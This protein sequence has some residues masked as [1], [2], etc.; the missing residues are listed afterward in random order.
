MNNVTNSY[1]RSTYIHMTIKARLPLITSSCLLV[2]LLSV[3]LDV[4]IIATIRLRNF[5]R[6][7]F[8]RALESAQ[9]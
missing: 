4:L 6:L 1:Y 2:S 3:N 9:N 5:N 7:P 8:L